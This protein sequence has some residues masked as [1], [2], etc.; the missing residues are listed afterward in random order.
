MANIDPHKIREQLKERKQQEV[1]GD[2]VAPDIQLH[3]FVCP[4]CKGDG[5][6]DGHICA[7]CNGSGRK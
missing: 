4:P 5:K 2:I 6:V 3:D 7:A 1:N